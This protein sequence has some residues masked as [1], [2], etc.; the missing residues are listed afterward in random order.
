MF[1]KILIIFVALC[2]I[3]FLGGCQNPQQES[4][5]IAFDT[6]GGTPMEEISILP[7]QNAYILD[8]PTK[9]GHTFDWWYL[10]T[11][12]TTPY[13]EEQPLFSDI[14]LY[15]KWIVN[16]Y[17]IVFQT[18]GGSSIANVLID[19]NDQL[20]EPIAPTRFGYDFIGWYSDSN[21]TTLYAFSNPVYTDLILY[22]KWEET[23]IP[24]VDLEEYDAYYIVTSPGED[25]STTVLIN[26]H[27][28]NQ[29]TSVEYTTADD[30][31]YSNKTIVTGTLYGFESLSS[32]MEKPFERR[33]VCRVTISNL[34]PNTR[35]KYRINQGNDTYTDEYYFKTSGGDSQTSFLFMT[36][37]HYYDGYDGAEI[38]E[39]TI[40]KAQILRP[41]LDFVLTT[42]D[43]ID[44]GGNADDWD[45]QFTHSL[46][47]KDFPFLAVPGNHE[48]YEIGT[49]RN[50]IF[51][52]YYHFPQNGISEYKGASYF[53]IHND[54]LFIQIDTD[55]P[56]DQGK[57]LVWMDQVISDHPTKFIIVGTHAPVNFTTS[58]DYNRTFMEVMEKHSVDLVL[59]G[60]YHNDSFLT[61]YLDQ[62]PTNPNIGITYQNGAGAGIKAIGTADPLQF[63]KGYVIDVLED[64]IVLTYINANGDILAT[65]TVTNKKLAPQEETTIEELIASIIAI[66]NTVTNTITFEWSSKFY[67][68]VEKMTLSEDYRT[69]RSIE[70]IFPTPGYITHTFDQFKL[71]YEY[72]YTFTIIVDDETTRTVHFDYDYKNGINLIAS[73]ITSDSVTLTYDP[74]TEDDIDIIK[75]YE[76]YVNGILNK[77]Y[78]A[79]DVNNAFALVTTTSLTGLQSNTD[80]DVIIKVYGRNGYLYSDQVSFKTN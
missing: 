32:A 69:Q 55:S 67:K 9:E 47:F 5:T 79:K 76:V 28:K 12:Y 2:T 37:V 59:S 51:S 75:N 43:M 24:L 38:C 22:A 52:A 50:K 23:S 11:T 19:Y 48:H 78:N 56:Y 63:A 64:R 4:I 66:P 26:Y 54:T 30:L 21:L 45:K 17:T 62:A 29:L 57:Q 3:V 61:R 36:D 25:A 53:F 6:M 72:A 40:K 68:N 35:Y 65:R 39:E 70:F 1:K 27:T 73:N 44:T 74:P 49:M 34:T 60:H 14:T 8:E 7:G 80:Y 20:V 31:D 71:G 15:A 42:G 77:T 16:T 33:N 10:E 58:T 46:S 41:E 13:N 18:N